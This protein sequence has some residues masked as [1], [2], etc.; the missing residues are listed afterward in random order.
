MSPSFDFAFEGFRIIRERPKLIL[1]WGAVT[2]FAEVVMRI[3]FVTFGGAGIAAFNA[4]RVQV[5]T[6][7]MSALAESAMLKMMDGLLPGVAAAFPIYMISTTV[8]TCAACRAAL[9]NGDD[10]LGFL[11]FG[12]RELQVLVVRIATLLIQLAALLGCTIAGAIIGQALSVVSTA[13]ANMCMVL[14]MLAGIGLVFW[15]SI[16]LSL[17]AVQTFDNW[18]ID[19]FGSFKLTHERFWPLVTGY[20]VAFVMGIIVMFLCGQV[21]APV[22]V[23]GFG[24]SD[25]QGL[26]T[27]M[28]IRDLMQPA[29][30]AALVMAAGIVVPLLNALSMGAP[31]AA[32]RQI[33][34]SV[35]K[36]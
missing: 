23:L 3:V 20:A 18:R 9:G 34:T 2:L 19:I 22:F 7:N 13:F 26:G 21:M 25:T 31:A 15:L 35:S 32:Y 5:E 17:N 8:I 16:R 12:L 33:K 29:Q 1:L 24:I 30:I 27:P 36:A 4:F 11:S 10:R 28:T 14:G 6:Q